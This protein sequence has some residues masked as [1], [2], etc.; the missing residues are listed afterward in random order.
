MKKVLS[1]LRRVPITKYWFI[2]SAFTHLNNLKMRPA[3]KA[4]AYVLILTHLLC[5]KIEF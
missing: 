2:L 1:V 3:H 4:D 5:E